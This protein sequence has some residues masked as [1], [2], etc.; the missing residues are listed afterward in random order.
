MISLKTF[1]AICLISC[2]LL[3]WPFGWHLILTWSDHYP[4]NSFHWD[5]SVFGDKCIF[6]DSFCL[7]FKVF[8]VIY[9][10]WLTKC[11]DFYQRFIDCPPT[12]YQSGG[13]RAWLDGIIIKLGCKTASLHPHRLQTD[14]VFPLAIHCLEKLMLTS[15]L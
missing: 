8:L 9:I 4:G 10:Q 3:T 11:E 5:R 7:P 15:I 14:L 2:Y 6:A 12:N 1:S 13:V